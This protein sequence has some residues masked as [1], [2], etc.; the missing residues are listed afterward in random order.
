MLTCWRNHWLRTT[1]L[2]ALPSDLLICSCYVHFHGLTKLTSGELLLAAEM[3]LPV[4]VEE[5]KPE[6]CKDE[7]DCGTADAESPSYQVDSCL[8]SMDVVKG[9]N[10]TD[11]ILKSLEEKEEIGTGKLTDKEVDLPHVVVVHNQR[12]SNLGVND[13]THED[14]TDRKRQQSGDLKSSGVKAEGT[15]EP[16]EESDC[17]IIENSQ[18]LGNGG[19]EKKIG[20]KAL[21]LKKGVASR[22]RV[23]PRLIQG[24]W[25]T[26]RVNKRYTG[27][28]AVLI[29]SSHGRCV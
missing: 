27:T 7:L 10:D 24:S 5:T 15:E 12:E 11:L 28:N 29:G 21:S 23:S 16:D 19:T 8:K 20:S 3:S 18:P 6:E 9:V 4:D 25:G 1:V 14:Q 2:I 22:L 26:S 17:F 13:V